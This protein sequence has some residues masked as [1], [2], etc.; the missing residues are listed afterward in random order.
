MPNRQPKEATYTY[1][2]PREYILEEFFNI[3]NGTVIFWGSADVEIVEAGEWKEDDG[4]DSLG[5][6]EYA[7]S[8]KRCIFLITQE[9]AFYVR[10]DVILCVALLN[11]ILFPEEVFVYYL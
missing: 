3:S 11:N 1:V 10:Y 9:L 4:E 2:D 5:A 8:C 7:P 6:E